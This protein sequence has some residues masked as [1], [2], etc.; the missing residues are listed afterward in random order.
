MGP[1]GG[2][3]KYSVEGGGDAGRTDIHWQTP[4]NGGTVGVLLDHIISLCVG[5]DRLHGRGEDMGPAVAIA[6]GR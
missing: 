1:G 6:G 5:G 2:K 3:G 4:S